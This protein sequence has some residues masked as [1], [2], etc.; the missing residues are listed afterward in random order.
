MRITIEVVATPAEADDLANELMSYARDVE[1]VEILNYW[2]E[3]S[4]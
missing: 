3:E 2:I 4:T 1:Q